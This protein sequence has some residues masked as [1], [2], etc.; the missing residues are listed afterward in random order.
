MTTSRRV[1]ALAPRLRGCR[2]VLTLGVRPNLGDYD[3]EALAAIRSAT[4]IYYPSAFFADLFA[5]LG[6]PTFPSSHTYR[7]AQD[8]IKQSALFA[9]AGIPHPRTQVFYG[10]RQKA[11]ILERFELPL[12]VKVP[13]GSAMGRGVQLV[14]ERAQLAAIVRRP[15]PAYIQ[16]YLPGGLDI[17]VVVIGRRAAHAYWRI[18]PPHDFR[19]N[20][21]Q[22]G[23]ISLAPVPQEAIDLALHTAHTCG[24]DDAG[25]DI[26]PADGHYVV[27][28]ANMRYGR[29]GFRQAG[30]DYMELMER[31]IDDEEI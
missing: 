23:R 26:C 16:E 30:I 11:C 20:V 12:I 13:R 31:L 9:L 10:K 6:K 14:R 17:R 19:C 15:I 29:E 24:W 21:A 2:N 1:I 27:L 8:K 3:Q 22:G 4:K 7:Y 18:A 5:A 28:E 25:I